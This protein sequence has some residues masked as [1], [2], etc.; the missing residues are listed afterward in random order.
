[1]STVFY[2]LLYQINTRVRQ[3]KF[4][5]DTS[6]LLGL[7]DW[8]DT[9][10]DQIAAQGFHWVWL[11]G[12]WETGA[13]GQHVSRT[14]PAWQ[15]SFKACLPDLSETDI[16]GSCFA[17]TH[18]RVADRFGGDEAL[19]RL[20][21]KLNERGLRLM[22][23]FV[24][25][26]TALDHPWVQM[27]P[28]FYI[29]GT[30]KDLEQHP[31]NY[32]A[33]K[34]DSSDVDQQ[35]FAYGRDP[36][37]DGWPDALQQAMLE[38]LLRVA[39]HCDGVRCDMAMLLLPQIFERT[40]HRS[41]EPFWSVVIPAVRKRFP[42]FLFLAEVYWD[43]EWA[44]QQEGFDYTYDKR[45]YDR[46]LDQ[47][48]RPIRDHLVADIDYQRK[49]TRFLENHD[50]R[51]AAA[52]FPPEVHEAAAMINYLAP[53]MRFFHAGQ[54]EGKQIHIP[55]HLCRGPDEPIDLRLSRFYQRLLQVLRKPLLQYGSWELL[56]CLP[57]WKG[58]ETWNNFI[59]YHWQEEN[60]DTLLIVVNYAP[61][62][63]QCRVKLSAPQPEAEIKPWHDL[64]NP[65]E[66][67]S[68]QEESITRL[69]FDLPA[70]G[71]HVLEKQT[72]YTDQ[73]NAGSS[74]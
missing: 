66:Q 61:H 18:Y 6:V 24:P 52:S 21:R 23:D 39:E 48:A 44:L 7:D 46:L 17:I 27:H 53:G 1:M 54:L 38:E 68:V 47:A 65:G 15:E 62:A 40:W 5:H 74:G 59:I 67:L 63:G 11:L 34:S 26:H 49:L 28:E 13:A 3:H 4:S 32:I 72:D 69:F 57:A 64:M 10:W 73:N 45:L 50:E 55:I 12:V 60:G 41:I 42:E 71:Y 14:H 25:N 8:P 70:W 16:C 31:Q 20:R 36:F 19:Q 51:R 35:I 43:Q 33:L 22:L 58:N 56:E 29:R 2:P 37:F 9:E 30:Q